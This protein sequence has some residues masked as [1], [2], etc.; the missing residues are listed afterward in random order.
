MQI[1]KLI[2]RPETEGQNKAHNAIIKVSEEG[3]EICPS[4]R[5]WKAIGL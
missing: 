5:S 1:S 3:N 4:N 2:S